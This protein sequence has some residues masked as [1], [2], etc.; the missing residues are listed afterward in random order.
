[1]DRLVE[2]DGGAQLGLELGVVD[3]V[4]VGEGLLDQEEVEGVEG[5]EVCRGR[6]GC[7][8][9][10]RRPGGGGRGS[11]RGRAADGVDV[12]A[13]EAILSLTRL[14]SLRRGTGRSGRRWRSRSGSMPRLTPE[15]MTGA[16]STPRRE[17]SGTPSRRAEEVPAG[18]FEA[19]AGERSPLTRQ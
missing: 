7:R 4:V 6:R 19:G 18:H 15:S 12:M 3:E 8:R 16:V 2:A 14:D 11:G 13:S 1:M 10:W 17:A 5:L 9:S